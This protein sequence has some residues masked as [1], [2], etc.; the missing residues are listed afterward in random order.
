MFAM[1]TCNAVRSRPTQTGLTP[2]WCHPVNQRFERLH[3]HIPQIRHHVMVVKT[4]VRMT[5]LY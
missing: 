2:L 1:S 5:P 3:V 4:G